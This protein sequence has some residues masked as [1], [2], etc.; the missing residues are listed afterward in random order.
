[1]HGNWGMYTTTTSWLWATVDI[2]QGAQVRELLWVYANLTQGVNT[3]GLARVYRMG[4]PDWDQVLADTVL[5]WGTSER[6]LLTTVPEAT[7][8]PFPLGCKLVLG[9]PTNGTTARQINGVEV[10]FSHGG[11]ELGLLSAP[12]R[13]YDSRDHSKLAA[14]STRTITLPESACPQGTTAVSA[15]IIVVAAEGDGYLKAWP[16]NVASTNSSAVSY[17]SGKSTA[18]AQILGVAANRTIKVWSSKKAHVVIDVIG[19]VS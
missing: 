17:L 3:L 11:G 6:S 1:M 14:G 5:L 2:P 12:V 18:N 13:A 9:F 10:A 16:G 4:W 15:N 8:G 19:T 7:R